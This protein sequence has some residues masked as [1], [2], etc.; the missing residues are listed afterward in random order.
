MTWG[1]D[2]GGPE[3]LSIKRPFRMP[4]G[5]LKC[6]CRQE[7]SVHDIQNDQYMGMAKESCYFCAPNFNLYN[8]E[9]EVEYEISPPTCCCG[10]FPNCCS[11]KLKCCPCACTTTQCCIIGCEVPFHIYKDGKDNKLGSIERFFPDEGDNTLTDQ[12]TFKLLMPTSVPK[13]M[14]AVFL[15]T[16]VLINQLYFE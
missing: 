7:V 13:E 3:I 10:C 1:A 6:C 14:T 2:P 12:E 15:A 11:G 4:A 9:G 5:C 8:P 16:T